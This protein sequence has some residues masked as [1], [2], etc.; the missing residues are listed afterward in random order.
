MNLQTARN[1]FEQR[2]PDYASMLDDGR[3]SGQLATM[4]WKGFKEA[5]IILD[6]L[7]ED[8]DK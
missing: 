3:D 4:L 8:D 1:L 5:I 6:E 2:F 7:K